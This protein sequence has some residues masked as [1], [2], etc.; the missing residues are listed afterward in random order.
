MN[1]IAT[2]QA[3][4]PIPPP[5]ASEL[6]TI[7]TL[8]ER[9]HKAG[10]FQHH[11]TVDQVATVLMYG[12]ELGI[13]F[14]EA[15]MNFSVIQ[16]RIA[17]KAEWMRAR[18][19]EAGGRIDWKEITPQR[20]TAVFSWNGT[21]T[22]ISFSD[23][24]VQRAKLDKGADANH[25]KYPREMKIARVS[26]IGVRTVA[27][28][29]LRGAGHSVE[30]LASTE[31]VEIDTNENVIT[32]DA[33]LAEPEKKPIPI[34]LEAMKKVNAAIV[35][36]ADE[37]AQNTTSEEQRD[38]YLKRQKA[39]MVAL[40]AEWVKKALEKTEVTTDSEAAIVETRIRAEAMRLRNNR[41]SPVD[42]N[43]LPAI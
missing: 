40:K 19:V 1:E 2:T 9:F 18:F 30:E 10:F 33:K 15:L 32:V 3:L 4:A 24:D 34:S 5:N 11:K 42:P 37:L 25:S 27:P 14:V 31:G 13:G 43:D 41:P 36:L 16:G 26:A 23:E 6:Q 7:L 39:A 38:A 35:D 22:P 28:H 8:S 20:V 12:R 29:V 21:S 17:P